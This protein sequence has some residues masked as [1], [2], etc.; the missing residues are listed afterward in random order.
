MKSII[1]SERICWFCGTTKGLH[2]HHIFGAS[3]KNNSDKNGFTVYLCYMHHNLG[4]NGK[5]VHQCREMD[6]I[7]KR[8]CQ[9]KYEETHTR[10]EFMAIIGKNYCDEE[11]K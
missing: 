4:G 1:Q 10:E 6:L 2:L 9:A 8:A 5:C 7:L 11:L 3:N